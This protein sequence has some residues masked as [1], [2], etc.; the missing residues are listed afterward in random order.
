[1][2]TDSLLLQ[3]IQ[4]GPYELSNRVVMAPLTRRRAG[5]GNA[6]TAMNAEYYAQ[7]ASA[8]LIIAEGS[9][10]SQQATGYP[11][12]PG[13]YTQKQIDG[14]KLITKEVHKHEG[15]IFLQLWHVGRF[16]HNDFQP[17]GKL[18]VAPSAIP[19]RGRKI[20]T[21]ENGHQEVPV[22]H[23]LSKDEIKSI[24][25]DY[26]QAAKNALEAGFDGVELHAANGYLID[27]FLNDI[28]NKRTDEYGGS[29]GN[30]YR[31]LAQ[32]TD[33][34]CSV[35][36]S[37]RVGVRLSPG[38][39]SLGMRDNDPLGLF[40][41]V[42][43]RLND[44]NLG[45]LSILEQLGEVENYPAEIQNLTPYFRKFYDGLLITNH[46]FD[47][48]KAN[49]IIEEGNSDMVAFGKWYISNPDLVERFAV[50]APIAEPDTKTY[51]GGNEHGY[52]DYPFM[53]KE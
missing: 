52:T 33:A 27:Q 42:V 24:I 7:R 44:L 19:Y 4:L 12:V 48:N 38:G 8:G 39:G 11:D 10:I 34:L 9:P 22:P 46:G 25:G 16:S 37:K 6:P 3:P 31:F 14:W 17:N 36:G 5:A 49:K 23:P 1:M 41:Y 18:P 20:N 21:G 40:S 47:F 53:V 50:G 45:Y 26:W 15:R 30:R 43:S 29:F 32:V 28:S 2:N 13:I 51:Y 35:W